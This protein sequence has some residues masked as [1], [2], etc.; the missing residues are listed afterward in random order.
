MSCLSHRC[1]WWF[2]SLQSLTQINPTIISDKLVTIVQLVITT[3]P[4]SVS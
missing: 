3:D 2:E 1:C 4:T